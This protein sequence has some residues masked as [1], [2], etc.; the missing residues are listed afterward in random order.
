MAVNAYVSNWEAKA[1]G[2]EALDA[3]QIQEQPR[4]YETLSQKK[5]DKS[6]QPKGTKGKNEVL[7]T[8]KRRGIKFGVQEPFCGLACKVPGW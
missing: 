8:S 5:K 3:R 7:R 1:T 2:L 4:L 6:D